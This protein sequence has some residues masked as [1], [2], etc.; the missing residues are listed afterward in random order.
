[1]RGSAGD[2]NIRGAFLHMLADALISL[3]VVIAGGLLL[4]TG[5]AWIDPLINL[6]IVMLIG[7]GTWGLA[8]ES[9]DLALD[10]V[11]PGIDPSA[12]RNYLSGRAKSHWY[13]YGMYN[14]TSI[15]G[16]LMNT[17]S[18][19]PFR[20]HRG[21]YLLLGSL[22]ITQYLGIGFFFIA[23]P[24]IMRQQG[25]PLEQIS[26]IYILGLTWV[27]KF[28]WAP[29]VDR[30]SFGH[31]GHY[32]GWLLLMQSLMIVTLLVTGLFDIISSFWMVFALSTMVTLFAA[33]QDIAADA[34]SCR[35]LRPEDRGVGNG[36][37]L[38]GG[39][40]GNVIGGGLV[41]I[42]YASVGWMG[43]M[44][45]LAAGTAIP[46]LQLLRF[47]EPPKV[48]ERHMSHIERVGYRDLM[49]CFRRTG[50]GRWLIV[51]LIFPIGINMG[52]ALITPLLVDAG[53]SLERIGFAVN[54]V[55]SLL[56]LVAA[57]G[58]GW[59]VKRFG[60]KA[61]LVSFAL[62]QAVTLLVLLG[63]AYGNTS[64]LVVA[65]AVGAIFFGYSPAFTVLSTVM[66]DK[67]RQNTAGTDYTV[68]YSAMSLVSFAVGG[69]GLTL[70]GVLGYVTTI[71]IAAT[72]GL[73][74]AGV[75][76]TLYHPAKAETET[77]LEG[78]F[79]A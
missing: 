21:I 16:A 32:R 75:V 52:Y 40:L 12:V 51:L 31:H 63:P 69:L 6:V 65:L 3:G 20:M 14:Q 30:F 56:G 66:M 59:A 74:G 18:T 34:L 5:W 79:S 4:L 53:W 7:W 71:I 25:M 28:L 47:R 50:M 17:L 72:C 44:A 37:Q 54:I 49:S 24:A 68:Q 73:L 76:L 62:L 58:A 29:L 9:L 46:V 11:P 78:T 41:L 26:V 38:A 35:L 1:M 57:L 22:Y 42:A 70:A 23:L 10:A 48:T 45:I 77:V 43:A 2:L 36:I 61:A 8:R 13:K 19:A 60:R 64:D 15:E 27:L 39:L 33:T 67:T 55:G